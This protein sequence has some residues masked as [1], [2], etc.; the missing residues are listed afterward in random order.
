MQS[1]LAS[2]TLHSTAIFS[3]TNTN[4]SCKFW[5]KLSYYYRAISKLSHVVKVVS[6]LNL[7]TGGQENYP[8]LGLYE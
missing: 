6:T 1:H 3:T 8:V 4:Q 5:I 7:I 2:A